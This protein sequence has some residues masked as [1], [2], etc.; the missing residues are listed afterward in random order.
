MIST[1]PNVKANK[2]LMKYIQ[3]LEN[4]P[5]IILVAKNEKEVI[6][7]YDYGADYVVYPYSLTGHSINQIIKFSNK[8]SYTET[9]KTRNFNNIL[10]KI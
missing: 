7:L 10:A 3:S 5:I 8:D 6:E 1:I 2:Q 4:K 9:Y